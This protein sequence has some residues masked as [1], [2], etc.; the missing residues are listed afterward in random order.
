MESA[1]RIQLFG[2]P[3]ITIAGQ[4]IVLTSSPLVQLIGYVALH[5]A[6]G[7]AVTRSKLAGTLF[8]DQTEAH[9]RRLLSETLYRLRRTLGDQADTMLRADEDLIA[10]GP[11]RIDVNEFR[12][13]TN[14]PNLTDW[15]AAIELYAGDLLEDLDAEWVL[16]TRASLHEQHLALLERTCAACIEAGDLAA[17][18]SYAHRWT[19]ADPLREEAHRTAMQLYAQLG[20]HAAALQQF[21]QLTRLLADELQAEPLPET[22]A[23]ADSIRSELEAHHPLIRRRVFVGRR[24]ERAL[25]L[26]RVE[27]HSLAVVDSSS[28]KDNPA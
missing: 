3:R 16:G 19:L 25:L 6:A 21:N 11:V 20:R 27:Q 4:P 13:H 24:R 26:E 2:T 18:L 8:P 12:A 23:L 14:A 5:A 17:A 9:A 10:L 7:R 1:T 15:R 28:L 22:Q